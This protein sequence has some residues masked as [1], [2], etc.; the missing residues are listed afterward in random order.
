[1]PLGIVPSKGKLPFVYGSKTFLNYSTPRNRV[2][3]THNLESIRDIAQKIAKKQQKVDRQ[4]ACRSIM[5]RFEDGRPAMY[6]IIGKNK[7][8]KP[9]YFTGRGWDMFCTHVIPS[10]GMK[11]GYYDQVLSPSSDSNPLTKGGQTLGQKLAT[12]D[13]NWW[14]Q[15]NPTCDRDLLFRTVLTQNA[16]GEVERVV[17]SVQTPSYAIFDE[18]QYLNWL[19][20]RFPELTKYPV[21]KARFDTDGMWIRIQE[22][23]RIAR[24]VNDIINC[25]DFWNSP[26]SLRK[27][28]MGF[29]TLRLICTN[30]Q[31]AAEKESK[32]QSRHQGDVETLLQGIQDKIAYAQAL[33]DGAK[34]RYIQAQTIE[35]ENIWAWMENRLLGHKVSKNNIERIK[36]GMRDATSSPIGTL[37]GVADGMTLLAQHDDFSWTESWNLE[38]TASKI[39]AQGLKEAKQTDGK[40][41]V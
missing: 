36:L 16:H 41:L 12:S 8:S 33:R 21:V 39:L 10:R 28:G 7:L 31:L 27:V 5:I 18:L 13:I 2:S 19:L 22:E 37:A 32:I 35:A 1:M 24:E 25:R 6:R 30:G 4:Y 40:L 14:I 26:V 9:V 3:K 20:D 38:E 23:L 17:R 15:N 34:E 11:R 29:S